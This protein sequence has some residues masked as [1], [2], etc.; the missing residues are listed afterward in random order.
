[1][2]QNKNRMLECAWVLKNNRL[3]S[4]WIQVPTRTEEIEALKF[5][6]MI[7]QQQKVA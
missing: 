5:S 6:M 7:G 1:M 4:V 3:M 2:D